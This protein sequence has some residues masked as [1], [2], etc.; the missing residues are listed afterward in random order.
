[1]LKIFFSTVQIYV[2]RHFS[3]QPSLNSISTRL[4]SENDVHPESG[5]TE[6]L[7]LPTVSQDAF[8][9]AL[10]YFAKAVGVGPKR[11]GISSS[12]VY[13]IRNRSNAQRLN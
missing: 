5:K 4:R 9:I 3:Y 13:D 10:E 1:M 8:E 12:F 11:F 7:I 6:W 2:L